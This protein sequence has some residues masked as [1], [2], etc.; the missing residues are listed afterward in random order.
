[1]NETTNESLEEAVVEVQNDQATQEQ[2]ETVT[3]PVNVNNNPLFNESPARNNPYKTPMHT[4][5]LVLGILSIVLGLLIALVGEILGIIGI[6]LAVSRR[7]EYNV[8]AGMICCIVGL[9]LSIANHV[10]GIVLMLS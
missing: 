7:W 2:S 1:M 8:T 9:I 10:L 4:P 6:S 5:S 3:A